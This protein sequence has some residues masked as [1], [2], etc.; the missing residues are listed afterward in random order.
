MRA[1]DCLTTL[2]LMVL[3][4]ALC[5][6]QSVSNRET[7]LD[8][9]TRLAQQY[10]REGQPELAIPELQ[11]VVAL[12]PENA[13][14]HGNLGVLLYFR[15][16][17]AAAIPQL[18]SALKL[19]PELW[20]IQ[21]LLGM[22]ESRMGQE[23]EGREDL[24]GAFPHLTD[25]KIKILVGNSLIDSYA[26]TGDLNQAAMVVSE[27]LKLEPTN[28]SLLYTSYRLHSDIA[29]ESILTLAMTAPDSAQMH[30]IMAHELLR[31]G[32]TAAAIANDREAL[33]LDPT[34]P[35][36]HYEL[37]EMLYASS[38]PDIQQAEAEY[39][40]A[41]AIDPHDAKSEL[42]LGEIAVKRGDVKEA[43]AD[44]SRALAIQPNSSRAN[45]D[46]AKV[47]ILMNHPHRAQQLLVKAI[48]IDPSNFEAHYRL[49][50]L[51]RREGRIDDAKR[52]V[53]EYKKYKDLKDAL[54]KT[55]H[56]LRAEVGQNDH[57]ENDA[58]K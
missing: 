24:E 31:Q 40:Q 2:I 13:D 36:L 44:D 26:S 45:A 19:Q 1:K 43:Y 37:A 10:L 20:K 28:T 16:D 42:R 30:Q 5:L 50:A 53:A 56:S 8:L 47:L 6:S 27:L 3:P 14:A 51:Y 21:A 4:A 32:N 33:K 58:A 15:N 18:R 46:L 48:Q 34:L 11:K 41:F 23:S 54:G 38:N 12:D 7:P 39:K 25:E 52:E 9:H 35:G 29:D 57:D 22:S 55:F 49:G 17:Y